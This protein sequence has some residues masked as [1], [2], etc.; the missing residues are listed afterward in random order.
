M[1]KM[2]YEYTDEG[3]CRVM[4]SVGECSYCLMEEGGPYSIELYRC[5]DDYHEPI[6]IVKL[7]EGAK[8]EFEVPTDH[9]GV[10]VLDAFLDSQRSES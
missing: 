4:Y 5:T 6:G 1:V 3:Y 2:K 9:Y 7:R 10:S 8:I